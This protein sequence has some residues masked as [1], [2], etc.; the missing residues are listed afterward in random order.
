[1]AASSRYLSLALALLLPGCAST[2]RE[3]GLDRPPNPT[4]PAQIGRAKIDRAICIGEAT[5]ADAGAAFRSKQ[6]F[7]DVYDRCMAKRGYAAA[8]PPRSVMNSRRRIVALKG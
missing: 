3:P 6:S 2:V 5:K 4:D 7:D 8:V 1:M